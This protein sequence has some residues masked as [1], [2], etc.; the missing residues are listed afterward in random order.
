MKLQKLIKLVVRDDQ[1]AFDR[2]AR[3]LATMPRRAVR[4]TNGIDQCVYETEDR[5]LHCAVGVLL[6]LDTPA[7]HKWAQ[8]R[9]A[10]VDDITYFDDEDL[11][12]LLD[13]EFLVDFNGVSPEMLSELQNVH[14]DSGHWN[15]TG[16]TGWW[17]MEQVAHSWGLNTKALPTT[18]TN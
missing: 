6:D 17:A 5:K 15:D 9:M 3:Q 13:G 2:V 16:F 4:P 7:K 18:A 14:D 10:G 12:D 8:T 1:Q 11:S